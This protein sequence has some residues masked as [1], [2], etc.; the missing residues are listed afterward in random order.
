MN[1]RDRVGARP[2]A[3][4]SFELV[5]DAAQLGAGWA[6]TRLYEALAGAVAGYLRTQGVR[7]AED[8]TSEVFLAVFA[9]LSGFSGTEARFRSWVFTI[10]HHKVVDERRR[11][12]RRP[13]PEPLDA[14]EPGPGAAAPAEDEALGN[15][16]SERVQALLGG[17]TPDQRDVITLRVLAD[18]SLEQVAATL[19]KPPGAV[20]ALQRRGLDA[21]RRQ[22]QREG[23]SR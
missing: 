13:D 22:L 9:R 1:A 20:K 2:P 3:G 17:L 7:E 6:R 8:V 12:S 23:V 16:G 19:R 10:A 21:L 14:R 18:L 4:E 11:R 15:L 5:L